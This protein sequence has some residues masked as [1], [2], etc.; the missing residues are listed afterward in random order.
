MPRK[1]YSNEQ[2]TQM[3]NEAVDSV[4]LPL[5]TELSAL[6]V[7]QEIIVEAMT[8]ITERGLADDDTTEG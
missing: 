8:N 6:G 7:P 1:Y 2:L 4:L 3:I 5:L